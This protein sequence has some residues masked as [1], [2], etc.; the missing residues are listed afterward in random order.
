M[1][2]AHEDAYEG[3]YIVTSYVEDRPLAWQ[4]GEPV[5]YAAYGTAKL[6][7]PDVYRNGWFSTATRAYPVGNPLYFYGPDG[8]HKAHGQVADG[9]RAAID[10]LKNS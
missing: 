4:Q 8:S 2:T 5:R 7:R 1:L 6:I 9:L 3:W 10:A